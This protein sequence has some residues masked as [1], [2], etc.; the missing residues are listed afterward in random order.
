MKKI[1]LLWNKEFNY[2]KEY[3]LESVMAKYK[4]EVRLTFG[5][6]RMKSKTKDTNVKIQPAL[7]DQIN[8]P[9]CMYITI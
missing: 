3:P 1:I 4:F 8:F 7:L 9:T 5:A 2:Y 6:R